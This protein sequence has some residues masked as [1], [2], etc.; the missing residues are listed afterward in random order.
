MIPVTIF[1]GRDVAVLG[2]GLSGIA[3][4]RALEAGGANVFAWDDKE[5]GRTEAL[6]A[7]LVLTDL[8]SSIGRASQLSCLRLVFR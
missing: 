8:S 4:A 7:G 1:S 5:K 2:L 6:G 3:S